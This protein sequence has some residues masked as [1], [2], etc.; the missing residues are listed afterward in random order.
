MR[1]MQKFGKGPGETPFEDNGIRRLTNQLGASFVKEKQA[2]VLKPNFQVRKQPTTHELAVNGNKGVDLVRQY[3]ENAK[4]ID[5]TAICIE[6]IKDAVSDRVF[7]RLRQAVLMKDGVFTTDN[8]R[9][10]VIKS[11]DHLKAKYG[12]CTDIRD[13]AIMEALRAIGTCSTGYEFA[14]D[15]LEVISQIGEVRAD[16]NYLTPPSVHVTLQKCKTALYKRIPSGRLEALEEE[17]KG[18]AVTWEQLVEKYTD[19]METMV[20]KYDVEP[21]KLPADKSVNSVTAMGGGSNLEAARI[22]TDRH[23]ESRGRERERDSRGDGY[24]GAAEGVKR[25]HDRSRSRIESPDRQRPKTHDGYDS[26]D[27]RGSRG[28]EHSERYRGARGR[29]Q[30]DRPKT[31]PCYRFQRDKYCGK[32]GCLYTHI[33]EDTT[34]GVR[35]DGQSKSATGKRKEM[36]S[37]G[38][39]PATPAPT[40]DDED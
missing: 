29:G 21:T 36:T 39:R 9:T 17:T 24:G 34:T 27:S 13:E 1:G 33:P 16:G 28:S 25:Y 18:A 22:R 26:Q 5:G 11:M 6:L 40:S 2:S 4:E 37:A 7:D 14:Q 23:E 8:S 10:Q 38:T 35:K 32:E 12:E 31:K 20:A 30:E 19:K 15:V 3:R